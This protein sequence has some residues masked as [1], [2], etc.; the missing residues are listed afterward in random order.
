MIVKTIT[1][2]TQFTAR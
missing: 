2:T 1:I